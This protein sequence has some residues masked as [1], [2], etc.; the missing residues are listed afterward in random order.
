MKLMLL[1]G[2][3]K[4]YNVDNAEDDDDDGDIIHMCSP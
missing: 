1:I 3:Q 2:N 4:C